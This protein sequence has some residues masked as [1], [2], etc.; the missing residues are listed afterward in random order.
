[1][2]NLGLLALF[3]L[4]AC[5]QHTA[6]S[7]D[8]RVAIAQALENDPDN[9]AYVVEVMEGNRRAIDTFIRLCHP[10]STLQP[11]KFQLVAEVATSG[12][13]ENVV[14]QPDSEPTKCFARMFSQL[15]I[16][17]SRPSGFEQR[18]FPIFVNINHDK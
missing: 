17:S 13:I 2:K 3:S 8:E 9:L 5:S 7:F 1:M 11:A 10:K 4:A 16:N 18:P 14:V 12:K 15:E 6:R